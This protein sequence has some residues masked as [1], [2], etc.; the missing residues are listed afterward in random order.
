MSL[1]ETLAKRAKSHPSLERGQVWCR[2]CGYSEKVDSAFCLRHGWPKHCG[3]TMTIDHPD[4]WDTPTKPT[5]LGPD[6][7]NRR[8]ES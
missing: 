7:G 8:S 1:Y 3:Y 6:S 2:H 4:T 5:P